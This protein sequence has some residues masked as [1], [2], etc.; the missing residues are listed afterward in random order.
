[1][2]APLNGTRILDLTVTLSGPWCTHI[3]GAMGADVI[4]LEKLGGGDDGRGA[5][6]P[7]WNDES[8]LFL[9]ANANKRSLAVDLKH[10]EGRAIALRL[11]QDCDVFVQN[12]RPG[13]A[14]RLGLGF[15]ALAQRNPRIVYCAIGAYGRHGPRRE[16]PGYDPLMQAAAG[17]MSTTGEPG[18][19]PLR[20]GPSIVDLGSGMWAAVG[21]LGAL[22]MRDVTGEAQLVDTSLFETAVNW[23][24]SQ[25]V[26]YLATGKVPPP[27]GRAQTVLVPF[28]AFKATD[29]DVVVAAGN[30]RLFAALCVALDMP[31]LATEP[32]FRTNRDRVV[33]RLE[34][35]ALLAARFRIESV[36]TWLRRVGAAGVPV[37]QV[38]DIGQVVKDEQVAALGLLQDVDHPGI[39]DL[40]IVAPPLSFNDERLRLRTAPPALGE[41]STAILAD[42]GWEPAE[43]DRLRAVGVIVGGTHAEVEGSGPSA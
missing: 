6:P 5:G 7:F 27:L 37:S 20:T 40:R 1:M 19:R 25:I 17:I 10:P 36:A 38:Q 31:G 34:L 4:K 26:G 32:R 41:H 23:Q 28:E 16:Q 9:A 2:Q 24:P 22:R 8:A 35:S 30:D 42:A 21:V 39:P 15:E 14:D 11:A 43:I 12:L 29:G 33:H 3:L 13:A 18:G